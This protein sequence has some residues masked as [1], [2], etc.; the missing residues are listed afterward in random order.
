MEDTTIL[1]QNFNGAQQIFSWDKTTQS[2]EVNEF[3]EPE[4]VTKRIAIKWIDF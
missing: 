1:D 3:S 2:D 4:K